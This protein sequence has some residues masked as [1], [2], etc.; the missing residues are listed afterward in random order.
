MNHSITER[1]CI[2]ED[3]DEEQDPDVYGSGKE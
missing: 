1:H 2:L 3:D